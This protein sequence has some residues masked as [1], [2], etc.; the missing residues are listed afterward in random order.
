MEKY[1]KGR[2]KELEFEIA[3]HRESL[4][5]LEDERKRLVEGAEPVED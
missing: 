5:F 3:Q 4:S 1:K 2:F